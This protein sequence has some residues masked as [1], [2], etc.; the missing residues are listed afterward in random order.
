[1]DAPTGLVGTPVNS[2]QNNLAWDAVSGATDYIVTRDGGTI[3]GSTGGAV[4]YSDSA[5][6]SGEEHTYGVS[7]TDGV[8]TSTEATA[9]VL[10]L[11]ATPTG[12]TRVPIEPRESTIE[13]ACDAMNGAASYDVERNGVVVGAGNPYQDT[14]L[15]PTTSYDYRMRA[16][17]ASGAS[18]FCSS[19][20]AMLTGAAPPNDMAVS[21]QASG[22]VDLTWGTIGGPYQVRR[23]LDGMSWDAPVDVSTGGGG[24]TT[25]QDATLGHAVGYF[26]QV[27]QNQTFSGF[28]VPSSWSSSVQFTG[29]ETIDGA[30][31]VGTAAAT[32]GGEGSLGQTY[33]GAATL[34]AAAATSEADGL[35]IFPIDGACDVTTAAATCS[36]SGTRTAPVFAGACG[37]TTVAATITAS[38]SRTVP[39][40]TGTAAITLLAATTSAPGVFT[41]PVYFGTAGLAT[42]AATISASGSRT[43]PLFIGAAAA[44]CSSAIVTAAGELHVPE[45]EMRFELAAQPALGLSLAARP[46]LEFALEAAA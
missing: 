18:D 24:T 21:A 11:P 1:M 28:T 39:V 17:N 40:F 43:V 34:A 27:R 26:Y 33:D 45:R 23:S 42:L 6:T 20:G 12:M 9:D 22:S 31:A 41:A 19:P 32:C 10:T 4:F 44:A 5:A 8:D 7:A 16:V 2:T 35:G 13:I 29:W 30:G 3:A 25:H 37:V 36:G 46:A 14:G 15:S 38:G